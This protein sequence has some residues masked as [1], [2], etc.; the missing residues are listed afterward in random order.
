M[1]FTTSPPGAE[2]ANGLVFCRV[3]SWITGR[4]LVSLPFSD[5]AEALADNPEDLRSLT[6]RAQHQAR[7]EHCQYLEIRPVQVSLAECPGFLPASTF[8]HHRIDLRP[9]TDELFRS[10]HKSCVQR[11]IRRAEREGLVYEEG[12]SEELLRKFFALLVVNSRRKRLPPQPIYWFRHLISCFGE[13]ASIR[14]ASQGANPV[15]SILTLRFKDSMVFKYGC[16]SSESNHLGGTQMLLWTAIRDAK[17]A[18]LGEFDLGRSDLDTSG[19]VAFKNRWGS[20]VS[21]LTYWR[22]PLLPAP[23]AVSPWKIRVA[24]RIFARLPDRLLTAAGRLFY[25]HAG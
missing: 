14:V 8:Y 20:A 10:F 9:G 6:A 21:Q 13:G 19:L 11:K 24:K 12:R 2:L 17:R 22:C 15:A 16:S 3:R 5:H 25:R 18:G 1:V 23:R 4:R 7:E